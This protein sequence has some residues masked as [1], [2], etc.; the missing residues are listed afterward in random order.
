[1]DSKQL[2]SPNKEQPLHY[3][4]PHEILFLVE[5]D[6]KISRQQLASLIK[7]SNQAF[8]DADIALPRRLLTFPRT[9]QRG[10]FSLVIS[11]VQGIGDDPADLLRLLER[12]ESYLDQSSEGL[13]LRSISPNWLGSRAPQLIGGGPGAKPIPADPGTGAWQTSAVEVPGAPYHFRH[14]RHNSNQQQN[15]RKQPVEVA[16]LDT[17]PC[18]HDLV[19]AYHRWQAEH[20]LIRSL[21]QPGGPLRVSYAPYA[22]LVRLADYTIYDHTYQMADH[23]LFV[24]G[25]VH[26]IAPQAQLRLIEV[27]NPYGIGDVESIA[28]GLRQLLG[29]RSRQP[30]VVNC[31][32]VVNIPSPDELQRLI[33][34]EPAWKWL[35]AEN[36]QRMRWPLEWICDALH[37]SHIP[38]VA[39]AGNDAVG[40]HRPPARYPAAFDSVLGVGA[41]EEGSDQPTNF[42]NLADTPVTAGIATFGGGAMQSVAIPDRGILGIYIGNFPD[43]EPNDRGWAWWAG[44]SFATPV[45]SGMLAS[46]ISQGATP[47]QALQQLRDAETATTAAGE[48]FVLVEQ[49]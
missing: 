36:I 37:A 38:I 13:T 24:A 12:L 2:Q 39:A 46:L 45:I 6:G 27:L 5:H 44:T 11:D 28:L 4:V 49:G 33:A 16:I 32:L 48:E 22:D 40:G 30:L 1:M 23:G 14:F 20:P 7:W 34:Q 41:L 43:G 19:H 25:I 3:F 18:H 9:Q 47:D 29:R 17:A 35:N 26:S 15:G 8:D 42:S 21:L 10:A 31:S